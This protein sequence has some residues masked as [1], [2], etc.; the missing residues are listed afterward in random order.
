[1]FALSSLAFTVV[2]FAGA[3]YLV[4]LGIAAL[5]RAESDSQVAELR[6]AQP[7]RVF[8]DG[9]VVALLN[10][11]TA[12]FFAAFL[13]QF[14]D[15]SAPAMWQSVVL[16]ATFVFI[17]A[18]TDTAYV[19]AAVAAAPALGRLKGSR[20]WGRYAT[21]LALIGMGAYTAVAGSRAAD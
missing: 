21:A 2:K 5:R 17:A 20:Q 16:G 9:F 11:K 10:P 4:H 14:I 7:A 12:L 13:P 8:R 15:S 6:P 19:F 3:A 18:C 1:L